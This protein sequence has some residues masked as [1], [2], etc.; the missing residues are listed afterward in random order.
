MRWGIKAL[1]ATRWIFD[2]RQSLLRKPERNGSASGASTCPT[3]SS[4]TSLTCSDYFS[5]HSQT[6]AARYSLWYPPVADLS[7]RPSVLGD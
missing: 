4:T 6:R 3:R 5:R 7:A 2:R 1:N